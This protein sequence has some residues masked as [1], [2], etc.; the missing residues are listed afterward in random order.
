MDFGT[1]CA[2]VLQV[3]VHAFGHNFFDL[4]EAELRAKAAG[5]ACGKFAAA[6]RKI[7]DEVESSVNAIDGKADGVGEFGIQEKE[8]RNTQRA[9]LCSV[10]LAIG[11]QSDAAA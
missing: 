4:T 3:G 8:F 9:N 11:F 5:D 7:A 10:R 1:F 6:L 2:D